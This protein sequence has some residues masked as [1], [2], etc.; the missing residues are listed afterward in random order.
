MHSCLNNPPHEKETQNSCNIISLKGTWSLYSGKQR[1]SWN[2]TTVNSSWIQTSAFI[3]SPLLTFRSISQKP[4]VSSRHFE[5]SSTAGLVCKENSMG[6]SWA[7]A[8]I[9]LFG[10]TPDSSSNLRA[11]VAGVTKCQRGIPLIWERVLPHTPTAK[12]WIVWVRLNRSSNGLSERLA[13]FEKPCVHP[14]LWQVSSDFFS[15]TQDSQLMPAPVWG[16]DG[17]AVTA[18]EDLDGAWGLS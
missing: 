1:C 2:K 3:I 7:Q 5:P 12:L 10:K 15:E 14:S 4:T 11:P 18:C 17:Q 13:A 8:A 16:S 6:L 9:I